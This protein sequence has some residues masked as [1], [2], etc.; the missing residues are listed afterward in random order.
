MDAMTLFFTTWITIATLIIGLGV[1]WFASLRYKEWMEHASYSKVL[2]H[3]EM[4][5]K[6]GSLS[7]D[8]VLFVNLDDFANEDEDYDE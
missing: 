5:D 8:S 6:D 7:D 4:Y 1:G 2:F 3:P